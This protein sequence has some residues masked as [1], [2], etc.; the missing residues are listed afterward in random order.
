MAYCLAEIIIE[1]WGGIWTLTTHGKLTGV[2]TYSSRGAKAYIFLFLS[3]LPNYL[4]WSRFELLPFS[5]V[6]NRNT[7]RTSVMLLEGGHAWSSRVVWLCSYLMQ[8]PSN[9]KSVDLSLVVS[10]RRSRIQAL[11]IYHQCR[12]CSTRACYTFI[13]HSKVLNL[14]HSSLVSIL[15]LTV[16]VPVH[17]LLW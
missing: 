14:P 7:W 17:S 6:L 12:Y 15:I 5:R 10:T 9:L 3:A 13:L 1:F 16:T 2:W 4:M 11:S 8:P